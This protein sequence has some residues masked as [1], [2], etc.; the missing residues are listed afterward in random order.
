MPALPEP[1]GGSLAVTRPSRQQLIHAYLWACEMELRAFKPGNVSVHSEGHDMT[2]DDFRRSATASAPHL[3]NFG[4]PLGERIFRAVEAT[5]IVAGCNTNLGIVL[6]CAPLLEACILRSNTPC[7]RE[8]LKPVLNGTTVADTDW[9]YR[10]IRIAAPGGLGSAPEQ[11]VN[12]APNVTLRQA[13]ELA[14]DRDRIA[15]QYMYYY[16][17]VFELGVQVYHRRLSQWGDAEWAAV[18]VFVALLKGIPDSHIERKFGN[19]FTG[20]VA[21]RMTRIDCVLS[22]S[23]RPEQSLEHLREADAMFKSAGINPG[24]TADL[25]VASLL[26]VRL[27]ALLANSNLGVADG[28][29][30]HNRERVSP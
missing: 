16:S 28:C 5:R 18:A 23:D 27:D 20:M 15:W 3:C 29:S 11:D 24:T 22:E 26:A 25:T 19:R 6:L 2:V 30:G 1:R 13:M 7:L 10:A 17:D 9:V 14:K 8:R 12:D 4:I 21:E